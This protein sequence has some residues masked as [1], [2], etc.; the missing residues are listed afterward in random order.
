V[1]AFLVAPVA[2][3]RIVARE[4][5]PLHLERFARFALALAREREALH[6]GGDRGQRAVA[7]LEGECARAPG[8]FLA[9]RTIVG[10]KVEI[11]EREQG[12]RALPGVAAVVECKLLPAF[13]DIAEPDRVAHLRPYSCYP[14]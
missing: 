2:R 7:C 6:A 4:P 10:K 8:Q 3:L 9:L 1:R 11:R 14:P 13:D 12:V 5:E